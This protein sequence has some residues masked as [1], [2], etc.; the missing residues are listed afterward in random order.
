MKE[1][2][3]VV[4]TKEVDVNLIDAKKRSNL[5]KALLGGAAIT[6]GIIGLSGVANADIILR[7]GGNEKS[8]SNIVSQG[9]VGAGAG[10]GSTIRCDN[11][12]TAEG[13]YSL[14]FGA[15]NCACTN[16]S[17]AVGF[18]NSACGA[19][20]NTAVGYYNTATGY[21]SSAIGSNNSACGYAF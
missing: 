19:S 12:N 18:C 9:I 4:E 5:K 20:V 16:C 1:K 21:N 3:K 10:T 15:A 11:T 13:N 7:S 2:E 17:T 8:L 6:A 14:S